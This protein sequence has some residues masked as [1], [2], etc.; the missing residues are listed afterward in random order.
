MNA[1]GSVSPK[2]RVNIVYKSATD[3][4]QRE[5]ELPF[6]VLVLG[7][8]NFQADSRPVEQREITNIN[9]ENFDEVM[10]SQNL[11]LDI[12]V[13]DRLSG[14]AGAT[15]NLHL[16]FKKMKDFEPENIISQSKEL[17]KI[18]ELRKAIMS[19][20]GPL[21]NIP[22]FRRTIQSILDDPAKR[23]KLMKE[24]GIA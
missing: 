10:S 22:E 16:E 5:I 18:I 17:Q 14:Q 4:A 2:E 20:K 21:G 15:M 12:S 9:G 1:K 24:L 3:M 19:L 23:D 8:F 11:N 13:P 7:D 6:K